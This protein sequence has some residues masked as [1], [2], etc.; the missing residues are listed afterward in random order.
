MPSSM[1]SGSAAQLAADYCFPSTSYDLTWA[2]LLVEDALVRCFA[3]SN[4]LDR[5]PATV[6][7]TVTLT[8]DC[9]CDCTVTVDVTADCF[10]VSNYRISTV[11][12]PL[13]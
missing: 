10:A 6:L 7:L 2:C 8:V 4:Y 1:G 12:Q 13:F 9:Y 11:C 5:L 3:V